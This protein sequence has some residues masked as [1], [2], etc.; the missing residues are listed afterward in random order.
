MWS[1]YKNLISPPCPTR[2][3][4]VDVSAP[5]FNMKLASAVFRRCEEEFHAQVFELGQGM[6]IGYLPGLRPFQF[7]GL[8]GAD[9]PGLDLPRCSRQAG[10]EVDERLHKSFEKPLG[11]STR[12]VDLFVLSPDVGH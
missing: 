10:L 11:D 2:D 1:I 3:P 7:G 4:Y 5:K 8:S 6:G 12:R 9:R